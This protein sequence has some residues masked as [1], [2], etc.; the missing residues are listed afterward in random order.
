MRLIVRKIRYLVYTSYEAVVFN[1]INVL[2]MGF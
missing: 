2:K 1:L